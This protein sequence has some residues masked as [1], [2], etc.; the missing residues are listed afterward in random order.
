[1][2][3]LFVDNLTVIDCS[4]LDPKR[5]LI[6]ASWAVDIELHGELDQQSM[7]F[8]FAKVKKTIKQIIDAEVDHKLVVPT[9]YSGI[10]LS[11]KKQ[12]KISF[13]DTG[14]EQ[15][16]HISP[17]SA[18]CQINCE[19]IT[20]KQVIQFLT[21]KIIQAL[22]NNVEELVIRLRNEAGT[23]KFYTYSHGLKKHDGNC[24]RIAHGHRS[25]IHIWKNGR[26]NGKHEKSLAKLWQD[27][28]LG[29]DEDVTNYAHDRIRFEYKTDQG[30]FMIELPKE[31]VHLMESDSTVECIAE[32][33]LEMLQEE[34][35]NANFKVKAFE[36]MAKGAI[37][38]SID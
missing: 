5:G 29:S 13:D 27:I 21:E 8:D 11:G 30:S 33:I 9:A 20:R 22:P 24:Q 35:P 32:H 4:V 37:A 3:R 28:Y 2:P 36:G 16:K 26:R 34:S 15:I 1:M 38:Q 23:G 6:G 19:K 31:R 7:V 14:N 12:L 10:Q 18:V 17:S 25:T